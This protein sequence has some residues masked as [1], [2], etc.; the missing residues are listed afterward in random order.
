MQRKTVDEF[1]KPLRP[2]VHHYEWAAGSRHQVEADKAVKAFRAIYDKQKKITPEE[3]VNAARPQD[4]VLHPEFT[5]DDKAAAEQWRKEEAAYLMRTH[6]TVYKVKMKDG[7][8]EAGPPQRTLIKLETRGSGEPHGD[9]AK[10]WVQPNV[11]ATTVDVMEDEESRRLYVRSAWFD[12][13]SMRRKYQDIA[14]FAAIFEKI[15]EVG[16]KLGLTG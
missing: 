15:D 16:R 1:G 2:E 13:R 8:A 11:Y 10:R 6:M 4:A 3:V 9:D 5:W 14:E 7:K 12:L